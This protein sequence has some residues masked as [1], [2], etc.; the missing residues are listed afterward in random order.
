MSKKAEMSYRLSYRKVKS[1]VRAGKEG[2]NLNRKPLR[3]PPHSGCYIWLASCSSP[4]LGSL[5]RAIPS[6]LFL[7]LCVC[8]L[9]STFGEHQLHHSNHKHMLTSNFYYSSSLQKCAFSLLFMLLCDFLLIVS[10][11]V[12]VQAFI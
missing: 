5:P 12:T 1:T 6:S 10:S 9:P 4:H 8:S 3:T 7:S 2:L 11:L